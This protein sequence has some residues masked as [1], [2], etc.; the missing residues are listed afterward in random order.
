M[1]LQNTF[2]F[3]SNITLFVRP[4]RRYGPLY[5]ATY[6]TD[7]GLLKV[8]VSSR[9]SSC[10]RHSSS[11]AYPPNVALRTRMSALRT[12]KSPDTSSS[13][14]A[15][16]VSSTRNIIEY[17]RCSSSTRIRTGLVIF[18]RWDLMDA[19]S[20]INMGNSDSCHVGFGG[21]HSHFAAFITD[22]SHVPC[23]TD[24]YLGLPC[25]IYW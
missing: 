19:N 18:W 15:S 14:V 8:H 7:G 23:W 11:V 17:A 10:C 3:I 9:F 20:S 4:Q 25:V 21:E 12:T 2:Y 6:H 1:L 16:N 13:A 22:S 24:I 5:T